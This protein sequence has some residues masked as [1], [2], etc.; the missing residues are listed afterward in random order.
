MIEQPEGTILVASKPPEARSHRGAV[1]GLVVS[2]NLI[3]ILYTT[4]R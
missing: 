3:V 1:E 4:E 2:Y